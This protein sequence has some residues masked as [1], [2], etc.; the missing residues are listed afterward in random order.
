MTMGHPPARVGWPRETDQREK[1]VR[2]PDPAMRTA[3][4]PGAQ[5]RLPG[6]CSQVHASVSER[7]GCPRSW[8]V[9]S[10]A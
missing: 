5:G 8:Q 3:L 2:A 9:P 10:L 1:E 4:A 7:V 6:R